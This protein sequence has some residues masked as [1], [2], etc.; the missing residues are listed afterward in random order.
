MVTIEK[1]KLA[2]LCAG[3]LFIGFIV[4]SLLDLQRVNLPGASGVVP[5]GGPT[6][7]EGGV[8]GVPTRVEGA[9]GR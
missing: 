4:A 6:I 9:T 5:T 3:F 1:W 2:V 8:G 7:I